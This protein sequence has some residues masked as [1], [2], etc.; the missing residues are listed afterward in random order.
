MLLIE[1]QPAQRVKKRRQYHPQYSD[2]KWSRI[3][4]YCRRWSRFSFKRFLTIVS[5]WDS[6]SNLLW[7]RNVFFYSEPI[8][9]KFFLKIFFCHRGRFPSLPWVFLHYYTQWS[10]SGSGSLWETP[11]S[12]PGPLPMSHHIPNCAKQIPKSWILCFCKSTAYI[13]Y[14]TV[15][16]T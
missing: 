9:P 5:F 2:S 11:D 1:Y 4:T 16:C 14:S 8:L 13:Q 6:E 12:N 15:L 7:Y 3:P 10:C